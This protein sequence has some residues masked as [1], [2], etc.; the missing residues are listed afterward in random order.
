MFQWLRSLMSG[1]QPPEPAGPPRKRGM[2]EATQL[3]ISSKAIWVGN[4]L[5]VVS[6]D[7]DTV[8]LF[9]LPLDG[10]Q[11][12]MLALRFQMMSKD[13]IG[14]VYPELWVRVPGRGEFFSKGFNQQF[15]GTNSWSNCELP[16]YLKYGQRA[17]LLK[18]NLV[19]SASGTIGVKNIELYSTPIKNES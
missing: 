6:S 18:F 5:Q 12:C 11:Q 3:P 9:E 10:E 15:R 16:F 2:I 14:T 8:R 4:E 17:D 19:F 13:V 7:A 1:V